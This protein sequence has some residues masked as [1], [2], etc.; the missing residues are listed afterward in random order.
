[1]KIQ[2]IIPILD[3][4]S[5]FFNKTITALHVQKVKSSTL[6]INSGYTIPHGNFEVVKID[7]TTFN[8][9]NTRNLSLKYEADFYL[10][11][12]QDAMPY[13][14]H[15]I[16]ELL[17]AFEDE[18]VV[19]SYARQIPY[20]DADAIEVFA[21][22]TNY[23]ARSRIKF[24]KDLT[25]LGIKTFFCSD[26]C[27]M[28]R[29]S[30]FKEVGGFKQGLNTN[31]DMEYA[32]RA[33]MNGKKV[34]YVAEAKVYH[35]HTFTYKDI[36]RRYRAIGKFFK[37]NQWILDVVSQYTKAESTGIKQAVAELKYLLKN[38]PLDIPRSILFSLIKYFA[39]KSA[40]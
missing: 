1:M 20:K 26:S 8:H 40:S 25:Q 6:L 34:A 13:D 11:M 33:I 3:P 15:L 24:R 7:K 31:E 39:F 19:V 9:A 22:T 32:A 28:Y 30:Y 23:P 16:A 4:Q 12:T 29:A 17:K 10:F 2:T 36:W 5:S 27:A 21:R 18:E 35:S 14:E 38:S 37:E